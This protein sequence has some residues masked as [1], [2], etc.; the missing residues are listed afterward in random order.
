MILVY[1]FAY[2]CLYIDF[3]YAELAISKEMTNYLKENVKW[4]VLDY[5]ENVFKG[6]TNEEIESLYE[7]NIFDDSGILPLQNY[8]DSDIPQE[9]DARKYWTKCKFK[10]RDQGKCQSCW[11]EATTEVL[12]DRLCIHWNVMVEVSPQDVVSCSRLDYACNGG[13]ITTA[14]NYLATYGAVTEE[15]FPYVSGNEGNVPP[16]PNACADSKI[17][18]KKYK[19]EPG[20]IRTVIDR[21]AMKEE[22][23]KSGPIATIMEH[24][25]D[26][27]YY[28]GGIYYHYTGEYICH[29]AVKILGW[30]N[31]GEIDYWIAA[32]SRGRGFG[33]NG[34]FRIRMGDSGIDHSMTFCQ[35]Q[36]K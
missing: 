17:P 7:G 3:I 31:E 6:W 26:F 9:F 22:I 29:N 11:A 25:A 36:I 4:E 21:K 18:F 20:S 32:N 1:I 28:K 35:A 27:D 24:Y 5:E 23:L 10:I 19:C 15:C 33:E 16:C 34:Y 8:G 12:T 13:G 14:L 30:G 2:L